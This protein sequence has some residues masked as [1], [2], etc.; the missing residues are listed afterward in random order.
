MKHCQECDKPFVPQHWSNRFC[1]DKCRIDYTHRRKRE[2]AAE[3]RKAKRQGA[4]IVPVRTCWV[5]VK[6]PDPLGLLPG[7]KLSDAEMK[8]TKR[9]GTFTPG[10]ILEKGN[11]RI[12][13]VGASEKPQ[14]EVR[15]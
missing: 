10:T 3:Y 14:T 12:M 5:V 6:D 15:L 11:E 13:I 4:K 8:Y 2:N 1:C 7:L 9:Y